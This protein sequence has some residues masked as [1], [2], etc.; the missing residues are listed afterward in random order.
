M[1]LYVV[2][3]KDGSFFRPIGYGGM[4]NNW[5]EKLE[6][7]KFYSKLGTAK[8][9]AAFWFNNYPKYGCPDVL[10]FTLDV[11][12]AKV[13]NFQEEIVKNK[14]RRDKRQKESRDIYQRWL[15]SK[16]KD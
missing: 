8:A 10:E 9:Q 12:A 2:R 1:N 11:E 6:K 15:D 5:Q 3:N 16:P 4:G 13:L 14:I 7:A